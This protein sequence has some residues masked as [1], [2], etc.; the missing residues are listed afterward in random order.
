MNDSAQIEY[1]YPNKMGRIILQALEEILGR[2]GIN[3]LFNLSNQSILINN[4]PPNNMDREYSFTKLSHLL[5]TLEKLYGTRGGRGLALRAGRACLKYGL[6]EFAPA[7]GLTDLEFRLLP[8]GEKTRKGL[9]ILAD[10]FNQFT[11]QRVVFAEFDNRYVWQI[12]LCPFCWQRTAEESICHLQVGMIQEL[13][14][15]ITGG[16]FY[17]VEE[18]QCIAMGDSTCAISI[19]KLPLE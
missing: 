6:R 13:L 2:N 4:Y 12:E 15:W 5:L 1:F 11:D 18:T 19:D 10:T 9:Q 14:Y 16:K 7:I 3:A 8:F 17:N